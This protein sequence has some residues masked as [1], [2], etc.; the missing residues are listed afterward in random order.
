MDFVHCQA[1]KNFFSVFRAKH[2]IRHCFS[3]LNCL[4]LRLIV[5]YNMWYPDNEAVI[6]A[7]F[8]CSPELRPYI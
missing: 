7:G 6:F 4:L 1:E 3:R 8:Y 2:D 5:L